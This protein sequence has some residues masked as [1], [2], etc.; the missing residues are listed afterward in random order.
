MRLL[1]DENLPGK[2]TELL[3]PEVEAMTVAQQGWRGKFDGEL[4]SACFVPAAP[5]RTVARSLYPYRGALVATGL[6]RPLHYQEIL[7][8]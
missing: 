5:A 7:R 8:G 3:A 6:S 2:L 1:L 4:S